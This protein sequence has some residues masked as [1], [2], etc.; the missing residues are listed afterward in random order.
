MTTVADRT[1]RA[2]AISAVAAAT[3]G[4]LTVGEGERLL[5]LA[6]AAA[7]HGAGPLV[8]V[9]AYC[10]RSTLYLA[11]GVVRSGRSVRLYS[12]DHHRGSEEMQEGWPDHDPTLVDPISGRMDSLPR[13]RSAIT[14]AGVEDVVVGVIGDSAAV[15]G[16][17]T[18]PVA[19]VFIDGGHGDAVCWADYRGWAPRVAPGGVLCFHDVFPDPAQGGRP[20]YECYRDAIDSGTF[21]EDLGARTGTLRVLRR[22]A[23]KSASVAGP[24]VSRSMARRTAAAE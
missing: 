1:R 12:I 4:F 13:W 11:A 10:G 16:D 18:T 7:R 5:A 14:S 23:P 6:E 19:L 17:S 2:S 22:S 3:P 15:A 8:E 20:P 21:T 9:G 24:P